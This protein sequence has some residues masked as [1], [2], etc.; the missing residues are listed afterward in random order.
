MFWERC[1]RD[2]GISCNLAGSNAWYRAM[3]WTGTPEA[4]RERFGGIPKGACLFILTQDGRE[5]PR[6]RGDGIGNA[7]HMGIHT[8]AGQGALHASASR[9]CVCESAFRGS[10]IPGGWNRVGLWK[11]LDYGEKVNAIRREEELKKGAAVVTA[12]DGGTVNVRR[13]P[14]GAKQGKLPAGTPV[15]VLESR[16]RAGARW[17]RIRYAESGWMRA[18]Y[19]I[20]EV[21]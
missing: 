13:E 20:R 10:S 2:A 5:P 4:C 12:P 3:S 19:L 11:R 8:G 6:Y 15:E 17:A 18:E 21:K 7:S 16:D 9:G 14:G 1:L